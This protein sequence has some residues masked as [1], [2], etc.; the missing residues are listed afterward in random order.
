MK[1]W[2]CLAITEFIIIRFESAASLI[3][4]ITLQV[5]LQCKP[6]VGNPHAGFD[7]AGVGN[8]ATGRIEAP[9]EGESCRQLLLPAP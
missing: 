6:S 4:L 8:G 1:L 2:S 5:K 3:G 9:A 7:E